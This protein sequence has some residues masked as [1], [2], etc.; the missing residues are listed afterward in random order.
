[1]KLNCKTIELARPWPMSSAR[2][3]RKNYANKHAP[4]P[5]EICLLCNSPATLWPPWN[6]R[7]WRVFWIKIIPWH[8]D[9]RISQAKKLHGQEKKRELEKLSF[10][11]ENTYFVS[12]LW[13]GCRVMRTNR[14]SVSRPGIRLMK[15]YEGGAY[16]DDKTY[17][18][19]STYSS[20]MRKNSKSLARR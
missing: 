15:F 20:F 10:E 18:N 19:P 16:R 1:M 4:K 3:I 14:E 2:R 8:R 5:A 17:P 13:I 6:E 12:K 11:T 9:G 7:T